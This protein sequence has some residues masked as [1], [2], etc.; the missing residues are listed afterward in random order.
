[1]RMLLLLDLADGKGTNWRGVVC[2]LL[3]RRTERQPED[4][5]PWEA[6]SPSC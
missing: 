6:V 1:M 5:K 2:A 4:P 3:E